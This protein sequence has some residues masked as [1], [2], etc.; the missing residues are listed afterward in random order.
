MIRKL[1]DFISKER[2][3]FENRHNNMFS[4]SFGEISRY[5]EYLLTIHERYRIESNEFMDVTKTRQAL[6][7]PGNNPASPELISL[8][9]K[10]RQIST[11]LHLEIESFYLFSKILLDKVALA[12]EFY[13]GQARG[14]P[15]ESHDNLVK[16][17]EKFAD[18][19]SLT[20]PSG[21][22]DIVRK[23]KQDIS[24][25]RDYQI[26]HVPSHKN[27]RLT[28]GTMC[29]S[30]GNTKLMLTA[31]Y[32]TERDKQV[33]TR[34]LQELL[35][36]IDSYADLIIELVTQNGDKTRLDLKSTTK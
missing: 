27:A 29:D 2:S 9:E 14:L 18:S 22:V 25:F 11:K 34:H 33:E 19:K 28:R 5:Y 12:L 15:F 17:M 24:D 1:N 31:I 36:D 35:A 6:I 21:F 7:K 23:L 16:N 26:A 4:F 13:F 20:L 32:P 30:G 8:F 3:K 10:S